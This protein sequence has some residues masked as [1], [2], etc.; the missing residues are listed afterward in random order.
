MPSLLLALRFTRRLPDDDDDAVWWWQWPPSPSPRRPTW[1]DSICELGLRAATATVVAPNVGGRTGK[2]SA[3]PAR[4][5]W[6]RHW[7]CWR[8]F[9]AVSGRP[10]VGNDAASGTRGGGREHGAGVC[11]KLGSPAGAAARDVTGF[12]QSGMMGSRWI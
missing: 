6:P 9:R 1:R 8:R 4:A 11:A 10:E 7:A 12:T 2:T 5:P 3:A